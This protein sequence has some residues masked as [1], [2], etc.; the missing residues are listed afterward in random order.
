MKKILLL[1]SLMILSFIPLFAELKRDPKTK[2]YYSLPLSGIN[3]TEYHLL[4]WKCKDVEDQFLNMR[5]RLAGGG[6]SSF[7][8]G[9]KEMMI[10]EFLERIATPT[11]IRLLEDLKKLKFNF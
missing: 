11:S 1:T 2:R 9:G 8:V 6:R 10:T 3:Q 4:V 7:T 5:A